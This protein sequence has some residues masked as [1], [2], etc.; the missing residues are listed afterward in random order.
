MTAPHGM[1]VAV[2]LTV[3]GL[4]T[5]LLARLSLWPTLRASG[6]QATVAAILL[7]L[8]IYGLGDL[9]SLWEREACRLA[10]PGCDAAD[11]VA[12]SGGVLDTVLSTFGIF[13]FLTATFFTAATM[14]RT[15]GWQ[16][17][18]APARSVGIAFA[19]LLVAA[20]A[21]QSADLGGL[22]ERLLAALGAAAIA[23][24]AWRILAT[25]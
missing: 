12:N 17:W 13:V 23:A 20:I 4:A 10:E 24:V 25:P 5:I 7:A 19:V 21:L 3:C 9:L 8:S 16:G 15:P 14:K 22:M 18:A 1:L 6:W 2:I 11:Q